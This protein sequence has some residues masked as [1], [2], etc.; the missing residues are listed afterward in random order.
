MTSPPLPAGV[1]HAETLDASGAAIGML[2][3]APDGSVLAGTLSSGAI[4]LWD[5]PRAHQRG[6]HR[7]LFNSHGVPTAIA[8]DPAADVLAAISLGDTLTIRRT[9]DWRVRQRMRAAR[10]IGLVFI[11]DGLATVHENGRLQLWT[12][13]GELRRGAELT[14]LV[15]TDVSTCL[16]YDPRHH[17]LAIGSPQGFSVASMRESESDALLVAA[18]ESATN[19]LAFAPDG[20]LACGDADGAVRLWRPTDHHLVAVLEG[21]TGPVRGVAFSADGT[22]LATAGDDRT[23][24][25]WDAASGAPLAIVPGRAKGSERMGLAFAPSGHQLACASAERTAVDILDIDVAT[26]S[27]RA[28][29]TSVKY[30]SAKI[31]LVGDSGVGKTG[32]GWR[33]AHGTF[34][35]HASTHGQQFWLLREPGTVRD[36]GARCDAILWDL[37]GQP[38]YRIIHSLFLEHADL[39]LV[40]FD[41]TRDADPLRGVEYWLRQLKKDASGVTS[42]RAILVGARTDRGAGS[43]EAHAIAEFAEANGAI[44]YVP[45]S[46]LSGD[47]LPELLTLMREA[48]AW[49]ERPATITT[50]AFGRVKDYVLSL[51]EASAVAG[52]LILDMGELL[53]RVQAQSPDDDVLTEA[54]VAAATAHVANHGY[55][56]WLRASEGQRR[57]LLA[58]EILNN[59]AASMVLEARRDARELGSLEERRVLANEYRFLELETLTAG[60]RDI[61]LDS[62]IA[63]FL[64][65]NICFRETDPLNGR[66]YLVFPELINA[67]R[68][69]THQQ[70][71]LEDTTGYTVT[72]DVTNVYASLVVLLGYS[73]SFT[74]VAQWRREARFAVGGGQACGVWLEAERDGEID[75]VL[76]FGPTVTPKVRALFESLVDAFL[77][78]PR[79]TVHKFRPV[80]CSNGHLADLTMVRRRL[81]ADLPQGFCVECG[82]PLDFSGATKRADV[83]QAGLVTVH[84]RAAASRS[85]FEQAAFRLSSAWQQGGRPVPSCFISYAWDT[86]ES[87]RWV[88]VLAEDLAKAGLSLVLDRW[89][90]PTGSS[91]P[92]F[93]ERVHS[94]DRVVVVGTSLYRQKYVEEKPMGKYIA[95]A[96]GELIGMRLITGPIAERTVLPVL[97]EGEADGAFPPLLSPLVYA[98]L[99]NPDSYFEDVIDLACAAYGLM[100]RDP[101]YDEVRRIVADGR[102][103]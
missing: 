33:L 89:D 94:A 71:P 51:K 62:A 12:Y 81:A 46:A 92:R 17:V 32:L 93:V 74:R 8:F 25:I 10:G 24:R 28:A 63:M 45:T 22:L 87:D 18:M 42:P 99:R 100:P 5:A 37:A 38:D 40:L 84:E 83:R 82:A 2:T 3:W 72:G 47:G 75:L 49:D 44:A 69:A 34:V 88:E 70:E 76:R 57:I 101:L 16:A 15:S 56:A 91:I 102:I 43:L 14:E 23:V 79:V 20:L 58:P 96:E 26:L 4:R 9:P 78:R 55:V 80:V 50:D 59:L 19:A 30:V 77:D 13:D 54:E 64:Q 36:D 95:A 35:E 21:H 7:D 61:L 52:S 27:P 97:R 86:R 11:G 98:D 68:T 90:N 41:P 65:H 39:L 29:A 60:D 31:V 66:V 48:I 67:A 85:R 53:E 73:G 6:S 1:R 103:V